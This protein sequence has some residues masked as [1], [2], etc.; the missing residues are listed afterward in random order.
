M[1]DLRQNLLVFAG[2][3]G[4]NALDFLCPSSPTCCVLIWL[5][6]SS[7]AAVTM[8]FATRVLHENA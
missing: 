8:I 1:W 6:A 3:L 5:L 4:V 2:S 7:L